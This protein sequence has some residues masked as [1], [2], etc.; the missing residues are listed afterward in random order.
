MPQAPGV[1]PLHFE[2]KWHVIMPCRRP[3][4]VLTAV[5][6]RVQLRVL[7]CMCMY[8]CAPHP[9]AIKARHYQGLH[10]RSI[11]CHPAAQAQAN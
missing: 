6:L 5:Q 7:L 10:T 2:G 11:H 8:V 9:A 4:W 3:V 1:W